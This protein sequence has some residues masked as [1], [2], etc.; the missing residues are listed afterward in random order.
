MTSGISPNWVAINDFIR[1]NPTS[2]ILK[3]PNFDCF[4][5]VG[6]GSWPGDWHKEQH[7]IWEMDKKAGAKR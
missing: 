5:Y 1:E 6:S 2:E 3:A 7:V 4:K